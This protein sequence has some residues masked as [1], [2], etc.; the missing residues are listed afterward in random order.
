MFLVFSGILEDMTYKYLVVNDRPDGAWSLDSAPFADHAEN[1]RRATG[2]R[3]RNLVRTPF[4]DDVSGVTNLTP[5]TLTYEPDEDVSLYGRYSMKS[6]LAINGAT[7]HGIGWRLDLPTVNAGQTVTAAMFV[8]G[9]YT[10]SPVRPYF[11][12]TAPDGSLSKNYGSNAIE[13]EAM[14]EEWQLVK[15][16]YTFPANHTN[17][18]AGWR[19]TSPG[20]AG[21]IVWNAEPLVVPGAELDLSKFDAYAYLNQFDGHIATG[22]SSARTLVSST[23]DA[24]LVTPDSILMVDC[25]LMSHGKETQPFSLEAWFKPLSVTTPTTILGHEGSDDGLTFDGEAIRFTTNYT[26]SGSCEVVY[27]P[28]DFSKATHVVGI[29]TPVM[30][31]LY[32]DGQAVG[33]TLLTEE[34]RQDSY[35]PVANDNVLVSGY[36]VEPTSALAVDFPATYAYELRGSQVLAHYRAGRRTDNY[37]GLISNY[38]GSYWTLTDDRAKIARQDVFNTD[39]SW[40]EGRLTDITVENG[41]LLP[42]FGTDDLSLGGTWQYGFILEP[43]QIAGSKVEWDSDG[44]FTVQTSV[45]N[46][47]TWQTVSN[48]HGIAG[49]TDAAES[50]S[51]RVLFTADEPTDTITKV[52]SLTL[53]VYSDL[54]MEASTGNRFLQWFGNV[55]PSAR[56][57]RPI[58]QSVYGRCTT[59]PAL[60]LIT[61]DNLPTGT[62][63]AGVE[64]WTLPYLGAE[65]KYFV[66]FRLEDQ[67]GA[68]VWWDGTALRY[69]SCEVY[70]NGI[71]VDS[72]SN[73]LINM[74]WNH[75]FVIPETPT[76]NAVRVLGSFQQETWQESLVGLVATYPVANA[77]MVGDLYHAY[78]GFETIL[79]ADDATLTVTEPEDNVKVYSFNWSVRTA[80]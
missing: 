19:S 25:D 67:G 5:S 66:D 49:L 64:M 79:L 4:A 37:L 60:G 17:F 9:N 56:P 18:L 62:P 59:A 73:D 76:D 32:V 63:I 48:G 31:I 70:I 3:L 40:Q 41:V 10:D 51:V 65:E 8:K 24:A 46:D 78:L 50:V 52:R 74:E 21:Y 38:G 14:S 22:V 80:A 71:R 69:E 47:L 35:S 36:S 23:G 54:T 16:T 42:S 43:G 33:E 11:Q 7:G 77:A 34:Q 44:L 72:D 39:A 57:F 75:I 61:V 15:G 53:T 6:S 55:F 12:S 28:T 20:L 2:Q 45:D 68:R 29:H 30:N 58:E 1:N 13:I 27:F 26:A